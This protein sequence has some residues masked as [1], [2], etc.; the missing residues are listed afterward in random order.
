MA[1]YFIITAHESG[2]EV[3]D[4]DQAATVIFKRYLF[5]SRP[6]FG[7]DGRLEKISINMRAKKGCEGPLVGFLDVKARKADLINMIKEWLSGLALGSVKI[8]DDYH[9]ITP[10]NIENKTDSGE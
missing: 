6:I 4:L 2:G 5:F 10:I 3:F 9:V 8:L 7:L 1:K